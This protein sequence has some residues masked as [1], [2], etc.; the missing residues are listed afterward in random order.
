M[1][2]PVVSVV[3]PTYNY[4]RFLADAIEGFLGQTFEH[5][6]LIIVD[7]AST[8]ET[9][10]V[11]AHY[12]DTRIVVVQRSENSGSAVWARNDGMAIARGRYIAVADADDVSVSDRLM[13]QF[14][15][16]E[17]HKHIDG[18][19]GALLPV[20]VSGKPIGA[21]VYKPLYRKNPVQYRLDMLHG[22]TVL[23]HSALMFRKR[24]L[25][26]LG[27][28]HFYGSG[29]D[30]AF[31][32]RATRYFTFANLHHVLIHC[33]QHAQSTTRTFGASMKHHYRAITLA[34]E[35]LWVQRQLEKY[36]G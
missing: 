29:G 15:Y 4:G 6:E 12:R 11:I 30:W 22:K 1:S 25:K 18:V 17:R 10:D 19:G 14:R 9:L 32:L 8:D 3:M 23:V 28:Y 16:L 21:P 26:K 27:G 13:R 7:D 36:R 33:R 24:M 5:F 20:D 34:Q 2:R 35:N 31:V